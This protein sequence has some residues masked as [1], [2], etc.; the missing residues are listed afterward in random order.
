[1]HLRDNHIDELLTMVDTWEPDVF[2]SLTWSRVLERFKKKFGEAPTERSLRNQGRLKARFNQKKEQ[3]RTGDAPVYRKPSSLKR[4]AEK[5]QKL[6]A[7]VQALEAENERLIHRN[8]V[9]QKNAMDHGMTKR[10]LLK[11]PIIT[12]DTERNLKE[13]D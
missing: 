1:M 2:G 7:Q 8:V 13:E 4:A 3:L 12:K 11:P 9:M 5:I 10:Q 6:E